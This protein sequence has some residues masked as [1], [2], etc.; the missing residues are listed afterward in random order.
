[1]DE[2]IC[3]ACIRFVILSLKQKEMCPR[4]RRDIF[5]VIVS[6]IAWAPENF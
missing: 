2:S 6:I 5:V 1:M 4:S 3:P